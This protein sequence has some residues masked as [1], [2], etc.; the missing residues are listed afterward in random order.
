MRPR[1]LASVLA[2]LCIAA[3]PSNAD[4]WLARTVQSLTYNIPMRHV[5]I[6]VDQAQWEERMASALSPEREQV[7]RRVVCFGLWDAIAQR[8]EWSPEKTGYELY[9]LRG[10]QQ[11]VLAKGDVLN[12]LETETADIWLKQKPAKADHYRHF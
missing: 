8:W 2:A 9:A 1:I 5:W 12:C 7:I 3:G 4:L 10:G 11:T 6:V